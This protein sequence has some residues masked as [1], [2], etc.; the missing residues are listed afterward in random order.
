M[1]FPSCITT[2][3]FSSRFQSPTLVCILIGKMTSKDEVFSMPYSVHS[4]VYYVHV[5]MCTRGAMY[6]YRVLVR[7]ISYERGDCLLQPAAPIRCSHREQRCAH[8]SNFMDDQC[9]PLTVY[10]RIHLDHFDS[11]I[12]PIAR[13]QSASV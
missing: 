11:F 10:P 13:P 2:Q 8:R 5:S 6:V 4:T 9:E 1:A 7:S 12:Y 3:T